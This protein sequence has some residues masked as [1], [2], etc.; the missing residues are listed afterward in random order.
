MRVEDEWL[1]EAG[2]VANIFE[3][4]HLRFFFDN[5]YM[6]CLRIEETIC[7]KSEPEVKEIVE[8]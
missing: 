1:L 6:Y 2:K 3:N 8:I 4:L 7:K 5:L